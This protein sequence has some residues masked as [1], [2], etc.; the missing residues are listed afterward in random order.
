MLELEVTVNDA[1]GPIHIDNIHYMHRTETSCVIAI[2]GREKYFSAD[3]VAD[4]SEVNV[5]LSRNKRT[6]LGEK[7][8]KNPKE[9]FTVIDFKLPEPK[10][11]TCW[12][13]NVIGPGRYT[14]ILYVYLDDDSKSDWGK[15]LYAATEEDEDVSGKMKN[16]SDLL[17]TF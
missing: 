12:M 6:L 4:T 10:E 9:K 14:A 11:G 2:G 5:C 13:A 15:E 16:G 1:D 17:P 7:S 3:A 8:V